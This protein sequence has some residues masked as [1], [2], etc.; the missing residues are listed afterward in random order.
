MLPFKKN[1]VYIEVEKG[2]TLG[3]IDFLLSAI[4]AGQNL[5]KMLDFSNPLATSNKL[6]R[7]FTVQAIQN[8]LMLSLSV[9]NV[10]RL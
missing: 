7:Q 2:D 9:N 1:I 6:V 4:Q 8:S 10:Y 3:D 5:E